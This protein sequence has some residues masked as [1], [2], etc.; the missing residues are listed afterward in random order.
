MK[1]AL[2]SNLL[3]CLLFI[4]NNSSG[5]SNNA[6]ST[7]SKDML[8]AVNDIRAKGCTCAGTYM[9]PVPPLKWSTQLE[10]AARVH[11]GDMN[12]AQKLDH[13]GT[14]GSDPGDRITASGYNWGNYAENI[15]QGQTTITDV[16]E[17]WLKSSGHCRNIMNKTVTEI[18]AA[19]AGTYW[20]QVFAKPL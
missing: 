14:N 9:P 6:D 15:A 7:F 19:K 5:Q 13:T 16:I 1:I 2:L 11:T 8:K 20:T 10:K 4:T 12:K 3:L 17:S 18:G